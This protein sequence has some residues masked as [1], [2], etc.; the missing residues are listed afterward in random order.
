MTAAVVVLNWNGLDLTR[1]CV[2]SL[3]AQT[4]PAR[5]IVVVDNGSSGGEADA[6]RREFGAA[7]SVLA[8]PA[9]EGFAGGCNKALERTLADGSADFVALLNNDA[10]AEPRWLEALVAAAQADP[11]IGAVGSRMRLWSRPEV[12][13]GAGVWILSSG[14]SMPRGRLARAAAFARDDDVLSA[15]GGALLLR[16]SMLRELG[17]F[18][19]DFFANFEDE[20]LLLRASVAG[21]RVRYCAAAEVR[22]RLNATI[23]RVRDLSFDVRSVRNATWA[24]AVNL[25]WPVLLLNLPWFLLAN[26]G[27]L[28]AMPL[29]GR[30]RVAL[31]FLRGRLR[32]LRELPAILRERRR[33]RPLRRAPWWRIWAMQRSFPLAALAIVRAAFGRGSGGMVRGAP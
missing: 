15:C 32:A 4:C 6:L 3:L 17:L 11:R 33:L 23:A 7:I 27:V 13:D 28:V 22:H 20:D 30:P 26:L 12:L 1:A 21:W 18:R 25:P 8:L 24:W 10:E 31:A 2:R 9:N 19:A 16:S 29:C 14:D 5:E